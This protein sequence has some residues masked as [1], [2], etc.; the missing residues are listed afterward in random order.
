[1]TCYYY[2]PDYKLSTCTY[3][4]G[5]ACCTCSCNGNV[6]ECPYQEFGRT[7]AEEK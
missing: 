4:L 7:I 6:D 1:M 5:D 3:N 2:D